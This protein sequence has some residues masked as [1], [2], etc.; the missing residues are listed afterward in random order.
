MNKPLKTGLIGVAGLLLLVIAAAVIFA[1]TFDANRYKPQIERLVQQ[2]TGRTLKLAGPLEAA[3]WPS[4]GAK[5]AGVTLSERGSAE[6]FV[7][8]D[9]AHASVALMPLLRGQVVVDRIRISGLKA[10][11]IK[12]KDGRFNFSDLLE[13]KTEPGKEDKGAKKPEEK[14]EGAPVAFDVAGIDFDKSAITYRDLASGKEFSLSDVKIV[15]GRISDRADGNLQVHALAKGPELDAKL[16]LSSGYKL[17]LPKTVA[18]ENLNLKLAGAAAGMKKLDL[19]VTG[20]ARADLEKETANAELTMK[21]DETTMQ[22]KLG[23]AKFSPPAYVFDVNIDKLNLDRYF[24]PPAK[25]AATAE[26]PKGAPAPSKPAEDTPVDLSA[27]KD[28]EAKG[29]L[30]IG[31]FQARGLKLANVKTE[32][33]ASNGRVEAPHSA[34]LYEGTLSGTLGLQAEGRVALKDTLTGVSIGPLIRDVAQQD[35]LE[36]KGNVSLDV[37]AAGKSVNAMKKSLAGAAKVD[38]RDGAIKGIDI[39]AVLR[40][41]RQALGRQEAQAAAS[42]ERTD[43]SALTASFNI[44]NGVAHNEDLDVKAPL[45]RISGRGDIDIGNSSL[46]YV[47]KAAVVSTTKGQGGAEADEL[48]GVTVPVRLSGSFDDLK[49]DVNYG[50]VAADI[51][52]SKIGERVRG[53]LEERLGINKDKDKEKPAGESSGQGGSTVDKLRGLLGR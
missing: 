30:Q 20:F 42:A 1:M 21:L 27:L 37:N 9:N 41:A 29:V 34:N 39:G 52:K 16:D 44:K 6:Q 17:D 47:T 43:F 18:A 4:I 7:A 32:V 3:I 10:Q 11:I 35:R 2:K 53:R 12:Q 13:A 49:Y 22:A 19:G 50:A 45:F 31:A 14:G 23:L 5:V 26:A 51:A 28:L 25:P 33:R 40:K 15:T 46:D 8:L 38:L 24:P 36:G 48:S